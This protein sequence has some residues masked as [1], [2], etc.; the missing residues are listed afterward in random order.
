MAAL[1]AN[2]KFN[3]DQRI[4]M[5]SIRSKTIQIYLFFFTGLLLASCGHSKKIDVSNIDLE[6]KISRFDHDFDR[7][8]TQPMAK[9]AHQLLNTYGPFYADYIQRVLRAGSIK[10]TAYFKTLREDVFKG[11]AYADLKH[12]VDV[13]YPNV[14]KQ[15]TELTDAFKRIKYYYPQKKLPKVYAYFSGF[16]AQTTLGDGYFGIGLDMFLGTDSRFYPALVQTLPHYIT[17]RFTPENI[18][19]RVIEGLARE[20]MFPDNGHEK[21]LLSKMIYNGKIFYFMDQVLPDMPDSLK[22]GYTT[23]QVKWCTDFKQQIWGY[24]LEENLLYETDFMKYEKYISEAPFTPG[25][26]EKNESAP[27]LGEWAGWQ[28]VKAYMA[29]HPEITL[30]QLMN[31]KD[32]QKILTESRYRP[33]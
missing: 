25:L 7:M 22:I 26:G 4:K 21:T 20:D 23:Q 30:Q 33:K 14:D 11:N 29:R 32:S 24:F 6:V 28:I 18:T 3:F 12:D 2:K 1:K 9:E 10:D 8:R 13:A 5:T 31:E 15:E 27:K 17:V 19:P 16:Q